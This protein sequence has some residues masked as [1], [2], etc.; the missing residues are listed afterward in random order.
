MKWAPFSSTANEPKYHLASAD[1]VRGELKQWKRRYYILATIYILTIL[2]GVAYFPMSDAVATGAVLSEAYFGNIPKEMVKFKLDEAY[3][4]AGSGT[5][6]NRRRRVRRGSEPDE[7]RV[8]GGIPGTKHGSDD[9]DI[10]DFDVSSDILPDNSQRGLRS[11]RR[12]E[13]KP[14]GGK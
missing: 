1:D 7:L 10:L 14:S 6:Q 3:V 9:G 12:R 11:R 13:R 4:E 5:P 2:L 8:K